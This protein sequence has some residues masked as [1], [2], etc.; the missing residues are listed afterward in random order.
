MPAWP[1]PMTAI[2]NC[3]AS[4]SLILESQ[5]SSLRPRGC[6]GIFKMLGT[7]ESSLRKLIFQINLRAKRVPASP[8]PW[9]A[10]PDD[11]NIKLSCVVFSHT[12]IPNLFSPAARVP[13][14]ALFFPSRRGRPTGRL[15][16]GSYSLTPRSVTRYAGPMRASGP[17]ACIVLRPRAA[18]NPRSI[19]LYFTTILPAG[20]DFR[21]ACPL[22][23]LESSAAFVLY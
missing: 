2:S 21:P 9:V 3:P 15:A 6:P 4:Y 13:V 5:T 11:R 10:G 12:R 17:T 23:H 14:S 18:H 20:Q 8:G 1:A 19:I 16:G 7:N 22:F